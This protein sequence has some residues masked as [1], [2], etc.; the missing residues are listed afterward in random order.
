MPQRHVPR[1]APRDLAGEF[2]LASRG[3]GI[4]ENRACQFMLFDPLCG[5]PYPLLSVQIDGGSEFTV[6]GANRAL[7]N[8]QHFHNH[9]RPH[10]A[11]DWKNRRRI[12]VLSAWPRSC[13]SWTRGE[14]LV[15]IR[16]SWRRCLASPARARI[17]D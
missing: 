11:L 15:S 9:V 10:Q 6:A 16:D 4:H 14:R 12:F 1:I 5:Y 17:S 7:A 8:H 3:A 13:S 2:L